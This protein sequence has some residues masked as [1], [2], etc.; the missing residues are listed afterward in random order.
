MDLINII[1]TV[2]KWLILI[3]LATIIF[4]YKEGRKHN[5][6]FIG[7]FIKSRKERKLDSYESTRI[8]QK[9]RKG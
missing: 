1:I 4:C 6:D 7:D 3:S 8:F 2:F 9:R 5:R